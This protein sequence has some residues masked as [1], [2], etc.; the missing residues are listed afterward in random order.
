MSSDIQVQVEGLHRSFGQGDTAVH[1]LRGL[2]L[3]V[4]AGEL[5]ALYGPSGSGKTT[6]LN[7]IGA[8]DWPNTGQ[9]SVAAQDILRMGEGARARFRR[10]QVGFIFQNYTLLPTYT[11]LENIDLTL[12]LP[13]LWFFERRKR[14]REALKM[15]GLSAWANHVPDELSGGQRQRVAIA[16]ALAL[17]PRLVLAD[18]PTSGLDTRTARGVL[19]L[20]R[21]IAATQ[22]TTFLI[23]SHDPMVTEYVHTAYD[24]H[25]GQLANRAARPRHTRLHSGKG[26]HDASSE[27]MEDHADALAGTGDGG[28]RV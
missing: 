4:K 6:L 12:R 1:V 9:I 17:R 25:D 18:E 23:V 10:R 27:N 2:D 5:V 15:V 13:G 7:L 20:F 19:A 11:A 16:R 8:L 21:G 3:T 26:E 22:G 14:A 28:E 24:L